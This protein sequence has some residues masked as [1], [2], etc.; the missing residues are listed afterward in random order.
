[1]TKAGARKHEAAIKAFCQGKDVEIKVWKDCWMVDLNPEFSE[2]ADYRVK[3]EPAQGVKQAVIARG[4]A[5][6][7]ESAKLIWPPWSFS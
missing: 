7:P 1:M 6:C 5:V 3:K 4:R 2:L